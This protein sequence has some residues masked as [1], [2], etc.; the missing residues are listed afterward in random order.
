M[1]SCAVVYLN[2][3]I[4]V[5]FCVV[6]W[7]FS[8][9]PLFCFLLFLSFNKYCVQQF[10]D[11]WTTRVADDGKA[12]WAISEHRT[13]WRDVIKKPENA[14]AWMH[15]IKKVTDA[16]VC[17]LFFISLYVW[18][19]SSNERNW[20]PLLGSSKVVFISTALLWSRKTSVGLVQLLVLQFTVCKSLLALVGR[21]LQQWGL[22]IH[23]DLSF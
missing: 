13:T 8:P 9:V 18:V 15:Y 19:M 22:N 12:T 17:A 23:L 5:F 14:T 6:L 10:T 21:Q 20:E 2:E 7:E 1:R 4:G 3:H 11:G 16:A